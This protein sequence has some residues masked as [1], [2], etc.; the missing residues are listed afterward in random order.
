MSREDE[1]LLQA[2]P[3]ALSDSVSALRLLNVSRLSITTLLLALLYAGQFILLPSLD[4]DQFA[5]E[6]QF[7]GST[8]RFSILALGV[9]P[10]ITAAAIIESIGIIVPPLQR[11]LGFSGRHCD[12]FSVSVLLLTLLIASTQAFGINAALM[13]GGL[14]SSDGSMTTLLTVGTLVCGVVLHVAVARL[15]D[16]FGTGFGFWLCI[17]WAFP[18]SLAG[19]FWQ[20]LDGISVTSLSGTTIV[21]GNVAAFLFVTVVIA[22]LTRATL[23][24]NSN[25][26]SPLLFPLMTASV[27]TGFVLSFLAFAI[28]AFGDAMMQPRVI[29]T[30]FTI[31]IVGLIALLHYRAMR[32]FSPKRLWAAASV[33]TALCLIVPEL[34]AAASPYSFVFWFGITSPM[35]TMFFLASMVAITTACHG[36]L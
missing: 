34:I 26:L 4:F 22:F 9:I 29:S 5:E 3:D 16:M 24:N 20:L 33:L 23:A 14:V 32:A 35:A 31:V 25:S 10:W 27:M 15:I 12:P 6:L 36:R 28:P 21:L 13:A 17:G 8:D 18:I 30:S 1:E 7:G 19:G 2:K 11:M